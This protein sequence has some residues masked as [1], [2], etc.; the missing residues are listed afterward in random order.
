L[1][2]Y[3]GQYVPGWT[4]DWTLEECETS[5]KEGWS[6]VY[7]TLNGLSDV[8]ERKRPERFWIFGE[9]SLSIVVNGTQHDA[10]TRGMQSMHSL[11]S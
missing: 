4:E 7:E 5:E 11:L 3:T 10:L 8:E 2:E 1:W 6:Y 9:K